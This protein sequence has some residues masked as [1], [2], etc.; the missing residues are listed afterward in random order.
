MYPYFS[1]KDDEIKATSY[2]K[3]DLMHT[4]NNIDNQKEFENYVLDLIKGAIQ[5]E[6]HD[7]RYYEA[8]SNMAP[9][10]ESKEY[11]RRIH[12]EDMKHFNMFSELYSDLSGKEPDFE[13]EE[14]DIDCNNLQKEFL[15]GFEQK[16]ENIELYRNIMV[17]FLDV[18]IRDMLFEIITD[19]QNHMQKLNY[20]HNKFK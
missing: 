7:M 11:L 15:K 9:D 6:N 2:E 14:I 8:L 18:R 19:E 17:A 12:L 1:K 16:C 13:W 20:L 4:E 5:Q 3:A 10:N